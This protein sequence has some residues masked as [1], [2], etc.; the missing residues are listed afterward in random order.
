MPIVDSTFVSQ[1]ILNNRL[2][3]V[4]TH[5]DHIGTPR[6]FKYRCPDS[7]DINARMSARV[8]RLNDWL[9]RSEAED[10]QFA[11]EEGADPITIIANHLT[12]DQKQIAI[13]KGLMLGE[14]I[15][16]IP[17]AILI[18]GVSDAKLDSLFNVNKRNKIR[19][20]IQ[21]IKDNQAL[22]ERLESQREEI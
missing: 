19:A 1:S 5:T 22:I 3:V 7:W 2:Q 11:I 20:R 4:E 13:I 18:N 12:N 10:I 17:T 6:K 15:K 21:D 14:A 8:P 16:V 9:I